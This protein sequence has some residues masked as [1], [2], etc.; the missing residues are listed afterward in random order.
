[1][2]KKYYQNYNYQTEDYNKNIRDNDG[3]IYGYHRPSYTP[4]YKPWSWNT[5]GTSYKEDILEKLMIADHSNYF[6][7]TKADLRFNVRSNAIVE[8]QELCRFFYYKMI[9]ETDYIDKDYKAAN[10]TT[11]EYQKKIQVFKTLWNTDIPGW[12]PKDKAL[13]VYQNLLSDNRKGNSK[14]KDLRKESIEL[15]KMSNDEYSDPI[16][17]DIFDNLYNP[18]G[19]EKVKLLNRI[20]LL[21]NLGSK[22]KIEKEIDKRPCVNSKYHDLVMLKEYSQIYNVELYQRL[23][24]NFKHKLLLKDVLIKTPIDN[25]ELKQKIIIAVDYSGSMLE[26]FKQEWVVSIIMD[27]LKYVYKEECE[28]FFTFYEEYLLYNIEYIH[29][30]ESALK[31]IKNFSTRPSGRNT[32]IGNVIRQLD[33]KINTGYLAGIDLKGEKPEILII[34]DGQDNPGTITNYKTNI[35]TI[36]QYN[37]KMKNFALSTGGLYANIDLN[38]KLKIIEK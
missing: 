32:N 20:S 4:Y 2:G 16:L 33:E 11:E 25:K 10:E 23:L 34:A 5:W 7:P 17:N 19:L 31:F 18:L 27:R 6:T 24:P 35:L 29:N 21:K 12:T 9:E 22:F 28:I 15:I 1:M 37:E 26:Q 36:V 13:Y 8:V 3:D 38:N 30:K 14:I